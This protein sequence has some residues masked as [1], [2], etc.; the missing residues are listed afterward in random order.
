MLKG[1]SFSPEQ[2]KKFRQE[3]GFTQLA[4]AS[5]LQS[6]SK[7]L[8]LRT[9]REIEAG[10]EVT[11]AKA[12]AIAQITGIDP[13]EDTP[14]IPKADLEYYRKKAIYWALELI[15]NSTDQELV[16]SARDF[17]AKEI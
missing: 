14:E 16:H 15:Q 8:S 12:M 4:F 13:R 7:L 3:A 11:K 5:F 17:I 10:K 2:L 1:Y 9:V 6:K